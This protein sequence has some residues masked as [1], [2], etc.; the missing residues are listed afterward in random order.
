[1]TSPGSS[2]ASTATST[3]SA[4]LH[5]IYAITVAAAL[6]GCLV[7]NPRGVS[8]CGT[9]PSVPA[10][11]KGALLEALKKL[12][13]PSSSSAAVR[14]GR[15]TDAAA[16]DAAAAAAAAVPPSTLAWPEGMAGLWTGDYLPGSK[17]TEGMHAMVS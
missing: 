6:L 12:T 13:A 4:T 16:A 1:M 2:R 10:A 7:G 5:L 17:L 11:A 3:S 14:G 8:A 15:A 9:V